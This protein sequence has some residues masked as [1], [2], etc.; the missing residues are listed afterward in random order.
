MGTLSNYNCSIF[1]VS[2]RVL[3]LNPTQFK[4][5]YNRRVIRA[6][7]DTQGQF[8]WTSI[9]EILILALKTETNWSTLERIL[10]FL[11]GTIEHRF[12]IYTAGAEKVN[13]LVNAVLGVVGRVEERYPMLPKERLARYI[14]P[15]L[16]KLINYAPN[17][18]IEI[19]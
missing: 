9:C 7:I 17:T 6:G 8:K 1:L 11:S 18:S 19:W 14:C 15:V 16:G 12:L 10:E 5:I 13:N 4:P 3:V 2:A